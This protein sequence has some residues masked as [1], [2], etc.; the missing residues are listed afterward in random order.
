M[1]DLLQ[2]GRALG[3][4]R[5]ACVQKTATNSAENGYVRYRAPRA[6]APCNEFA[7][8][9]AV[10]AGACDPGRGAVPVASEASL[11]Q[12]QARRSVWAGVSC[13]CKQSGGTHVH[14]PSH[15]FLQRVSAKSLSAQL[16]VQRRCVRHTAL[17][18]ARSR[19]LVHDCFLLLVRLTISCIAACPVRGHAAHAKQRALAA[20]CR[21][22]WPA[23][24]CA[25]VA[26]AWRLHKQ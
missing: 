9:L 11:R 22:I 15:Y 24:S 4:R 5:C 10:L 3:A 25:R 8:Q 13:S 2:L 14:W 21:S 20:P 23:V 19:R 18:A 12:Q 26:S 6:R 7:C 17:F 16:R 1:V